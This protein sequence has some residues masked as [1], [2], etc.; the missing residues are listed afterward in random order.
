MVLLGVYTASARQI[1][2]DEA[3]SV[4]SDFMSSSELKSSKSSNSALRPMKASGID[5]NAAV[6]PYYIFNRGENEGFVIISGDDRA[7][8]VLGYSDKGRFDGENLPPQLKGMMEQWAE[9]IENL[10]ENLPKHDSWNI[11]SSTR[12]EDVFTM[13]T[14]EWGQGYPFNAYCPVIEGQQSPSGCV[15]TA[16]AIAMKYHNWPDCTRGGIEFDYYHPDLTFDFDNY[17]IDWEVLSD[18]Q[19]P[20]FAEQ[21]A[22]LTFSAGVAAQMS[23]GEYESAA[24]TWTLGH[25]FNFFYA[26]DKDCQVV[27]R[28]YY[29][30]NQWNSMLHQQLDEIGPVVYYNG[31]MAH[32]FVV[33]GYDHEGLYHVNWGW[34]GN[35]NGFF[36]L[37]STLED[38]QTYGESQGMVI[39][40][41]PDK[42]KKEY[43][44]AWIPNC[45]VYIGGN[46]NGWNFMN[47]DIVEGKP[48][49][50]KAPSICISQFRGWIGLAVVDES[51]NIVNLIENSFYQQNGSRYFCSLPG[52][53]MFTYTNFILPVLRQGERYQLISQE[54][55]NL[56]EGNPMHEYDYY[57]ANPPSENPNDWNLV[58]GG[59][60]HPSY[61]YALGNRSD[62]AE[63]RYHVNKELPGYFAQN[64]IYDHEFS[65]KKLKG[66]DGPEALIVPRKGVSVDVKAFDK[67]GNPEDA[68]YVGGED[69]EYSENILGLNISVYSD[70]FDV[71]IDYEYDGDTRKDGGVSADLIFEKDGFVYRIDNDHLELIGYDNIGEIVSIPEFI[72]VK[73]IQMPVTSIA[74]EALMYAPIKELEILSPYLKVGALAMANMKNLESLSTSAHF[75]YIGTP[76]ILCN[77]NLKTVYLKSIPSSTSVFELTTGSY[78]YNDRLS[79]T[80]KDLDFVLADLP[81]AD[82]KS[83]YFSSL[84]SFQY[85]APDNVTTSAIR[86]YLIPGLGGNEFDILTENIPFQIKEMWAYAI[87]SN[88]NLFKI[89]PKIEE[90][91]I[92][93][94]LVNGQTVTP[95]ENNIYR[96]SSTKDMEVAVSYIH[97]GQKELKTVYKADYNNSLPSQTLATAILV[98]SIALTPDNWNGEEGETF[99]I[100]ATVM[101]EDATDKTLEWTSSDES[102]ATV[103]AE[104]NVSALKEGTCVITATAADGSGMSASCSINVSARVIPVESIMVSQ[105][106]AELKFGESVALTATVVPEDATDKT[107]T[108]SS[109]NTDVAIVDADGNV[110][111]VSL[112]VATITATSGDCSASCV[113]TVVATLVESIIVTP[114]SWNG[115]EGETFKIEAT[116]MPEDATD[117]TLEWASSDESVATVDGEGNVSVLNEGS[118]VIIAAAVDGSG[119]FAECIITSVAGVDGIF[120][121]EDN[122]DVYDLNGVLVKKNADQEGIKTLTPGIYLIRQGGEVKKLIIR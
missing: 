90:I 49:T 7:P 107:V 116:V 97:H 27:P 35:L 54:V 111:A 98:E 39:N 1:T 33:D 112:G 52:T 115:E 44:R 108:W 9:Q 66:G 120:S 93:N 101:P 99:K 95:D 89:E 68:L 92:L 12:G 64:N 26:Y 96:V 73:G 118:C 53:P 87:D 20:A 47:P 56:Y 62:I 121:A 85:T 106:S 15:A 22:K 23:Y 78:Y 11:I 59:I 94:V 63:I 17:S 5:G 110:T 70:S 38:G 75:E 103:D 51:D 58:L 102:V 67:Y 10:S 77:S 43:S 28:G 113:V 117:K 91:K 57:P 41:K 14:A 24:V 36:T 82:Y 71:Y 76:A 55:G 50:F 46:V 80:I 79:L 60:C 25:L 83:G 74:P 37:D 29:N 48:N 8:K 119:V 122:F 114:E 104:G 88:H 81:Y 105:E 40:M 2:S 34:D 13:E 32:C 86:S 4:A 30:D 109:D 21:A 42:E 69:E 6:S 3:M 65:M 84:Q 18:S 45:E 16:M 31:D 100:E 19:N 72:D 61:F